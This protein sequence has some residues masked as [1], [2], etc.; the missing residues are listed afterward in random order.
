[1]RKI[2]KVFAVLLTLAMVL[3]MS[4]TTMATGIQSID[5]PV[6]GAGTG[7]SYQ[8]LQLILPDSTTA[9]GWKFNS[10]VSKVVRRAYRCIP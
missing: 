1:M 8:S 9:T 4:M 2:K 6:N 3:G 7:A 10:D 5:I